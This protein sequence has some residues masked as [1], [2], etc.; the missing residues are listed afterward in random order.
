MSDALIREAI[1]KLAGTDL[2]DQTSLVVATVTAVDVAK[3]TCDCSNITGTAVA[4]LLGVQLMAEVDDGV[5]YVPAVGSTVIIV[6]SKYVEPYV[7]MFSELDRVYTVVGDSVLDILRGKIIL[8]DGSFAGLVKVVELTK[9]LN[10]LENKVNEVIEAYKTHTH[11]GVTPG[12]SSTGAIIVPTPNPLT[13]TQQKEI[14]NEKI[15]HG[16]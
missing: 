4:D 11:P 5:L 12:P 3:R 8:N 9:K 15:V 6:M 16:S 14:E 7:A 13:P 10:A 2:L 1:R